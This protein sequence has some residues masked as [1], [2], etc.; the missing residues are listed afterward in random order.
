[1]PLGAGVRLGPYQILAPLGAGG[2]GEV[3]RARDAR[4]DRTVAI[5]I[6]PADAQHADALE[7]FRREARLLSRLSHPHICALYDVGE[8]DGVAFLVMEYLEGETLA[9]RLAS[10]VLPLGQALRHAYHIATALDEAHRQGVVH[11]DLK[12]GN[13][14]LTR[15]G[16]KVLDFGL[17]KLR[18]AEVHGEGESGTRSLDLTAEG[19]VVGTVPYMAP[20]QLEGRSADART[21]I[22]A[23]G[24]VLYEMVAG[25]R[26]F[27]GD[28]RASLIAAIL[29]SE[30]Q[31]VSNARPAAPPLLE[32][33]IRRCLAKDPE[34]RW[35]TARDL[36]AEL[37]FMLE[38]GSQP[39]LAAPEVRRRRGRSLLVGGLLAATLAAGLLAAVVR[40]GPEAPPPFF[41]RLT[42]RAGYITSARFAPDG[43]TIVYGASWEGRPTELF[44]GRLGSTE[45][46]PLGL[47]QARVLSISR[48]GEMALLLADPSGPFIGTLAQAPLAGGVPRELQKDVTDADWIADSDQL[49]VLK[50]DGEK[51]VLDF[52]L[53]NKVYESQ[54]PLWS[55]RVSPHGDRVA[56]CE[57]GPIGR[58]DVIVLDRSGKKTTLSRGWVGLFGLAWS[59]DGDEV[60]FTATRPSQDEGP[61]AVRAVSLSGKDRLV[62]R[63]P[64]WLFLN[65]MFRDGR[66]LLGSNVARAGVRCRMP[67]EASEREMGWLDSSY[68]QALSA[69]GKTLLF[70]EGA[71]S[72]KLAAGVFAQGVAGGAPLGAVYLRKTDG[73]PALRLGEGYPEDLSP[74]GKWV[75]VAGPNRKEW[76]LLPTGAGMPKRLPLGQITRTYVGQWLDAGRIVFAGFE[77]GRPMRAFVQSVEDATIRPV[78]PEGV[79]PSDTAL[80]VPGGKSILAGK[81]PWQL[82]PVDGG[83][84]RPLP[85]PSPARPVAWSSD[86]KSLY[87]ADGGDVAHN[88]YRQDVAS[89]RRQLWKTLTMSDLAGVDT[90]GPVVLTP[91]GESYCYTYTRSQST[92]FVVEG[93]K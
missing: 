34:E 2:M 10:G 33:A 84:P 58:G 36:A 87:V 15:A 71:G 11:R 43:E 39:V 53:G 88:V 81:E 20:E 77:P 74:D 83:D 24:A 17:A 85:F 41:R 45:A 66:V 62:T 63:A 42:F 38:S 68:A 90:V 52:P 91:D 21:D 89:G 35:Q 51:F 80:V 61:P 56:V 78:T 28:N 37:S 50:F 49:A 75:L 30:P 9:S 13:I 48:S 22:F 32:R 55:M 92:M 47:T 44:L 8:E 12:P 86:G 5:K 57:G 65:E 16:V 82:Y 60:W 72:G 73:S 54:A 70:S 79:S 40:R 19:V 67:G 46:R 93:L 64:L 7:R 29:T 1:M 23:F 6:L 18:E 27:K 31:P 26:P 3:Y 76:T 25:A 4:L 14:M 59:K 69:D